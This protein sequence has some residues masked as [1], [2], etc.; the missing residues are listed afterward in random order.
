MNKGYRHGQILRVIRTQRIHTQEEL[1]R[2]LQKLGVPAT[3]V[4]LSRDIRELGLV[5]TPDGYRQMGAEAHGPDFSTLAN[6]LLL[7]V[8]LAQN[9]LVLKTAPAHASSLAAALDRENWPEVL[10]TIAGDDTVL[11]VTPNNQTAARLQKKFGTGRNFPILSD[12]MPSR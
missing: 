2:E 4:T 8:R 10:G 5:K 1:A 6:E 3:Q 9:L 11:V 7:D 12:R